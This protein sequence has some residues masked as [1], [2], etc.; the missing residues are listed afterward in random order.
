LGGKQLEPRRNGNWRIAQKLVLRAVAL[1]N[2]HFHAA[3]FANAPAVKTVTQPDCEYIVPR[4]YRK[5]WISEVLMLVGIGDAANPVMRAQPFHSGDAETDKLLE[6][7]RRRIFSPQPI[8]RQEGLV[9]C[10]AG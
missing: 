4:S 9:V 6:D 10:G 3:E 1:L 7:A 2:Q 8:D 5:C